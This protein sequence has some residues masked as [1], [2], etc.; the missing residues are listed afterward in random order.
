PP[1]LAFLPAR[2][3]AG[4]VFVWSPNPPPAY[5]GLHVHPALSACVVL[6]HAAGTIRPGPRLAGGS[7][8]MEPAK[9]DRRGDPGGHGGA[10]GLAGWAL[11]PAVGRGPGP[12]G[13]GG[14]ASRSLRVCRA[15]GPA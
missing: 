8:A 3:L 4:R 13:G 14:G 2:L 7:T 11:P 1:A 9:C 6:R 5:N 10:V 12:R 15:C